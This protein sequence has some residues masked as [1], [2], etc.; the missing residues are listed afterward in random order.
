MNTSDQNKVNLPAEALAELTEGNKI[1]AI[2]IVREKNGIGLK[3]AKDFVEQYVDK[4]PS[5]K[6]KLDKAQAES[7]QVFLK[8]FVAI[9]VLIGLFIYIFINK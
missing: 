4:N 3:E 5:L 9:I 7:M 8:W 2:K 6:A 1:E